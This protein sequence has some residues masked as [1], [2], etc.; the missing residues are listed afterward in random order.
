MWSNL[1]GVTHQLLTSRGILTLA[2]PRLPQ[3]S[4]GPLG[5]WQLLQPDRQIFSKLSCLQQIYW[6]ST[7]I[8][9]REDTGQQ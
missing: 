9:E 6:L 5:P 3:T 7:T 2:T 1:A 8:K 4:G